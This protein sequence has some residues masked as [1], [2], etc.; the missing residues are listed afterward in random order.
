MSD[1]YCNI[2]KYKFITNLYLDIFKSFKS[3][4]FYYCKGG[5]QGHGGGQGGGHGG[6]HGL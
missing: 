4:F 5:V 2:N 1:I 6:G 3:F